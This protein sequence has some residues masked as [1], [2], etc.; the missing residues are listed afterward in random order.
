MPILNV[1]QS[2][3]EATGDERVIP[4]LTKYFKWQLAVPEQDFVLGDWAPL[5]TGDNLE[6]V[7]WLYN[8]TGEKFLLDLAAKLHR[9]S[10]NWGA[11]IPT[12]HG[13]NFTQGFR[14]PA[15]FW[16]QAKDE[17]LLKSTYRNYD[18]IMKRYGQMPGGM[19]IADENFRPGFHDPRGGAE[20]C[21]MV[22]LLH[23]FEMLTKITGDPRWSDRCEDVAF[24]SLPAAFTPDLKGLHYVTCPNQVSLDPKDKTPAIQNGGTMFSYSPYAVYRC[25]QHN[26]SHGWPYYAEEMWLATSDNGLCVSLY[27]PSEVKAK[28]GDGGAE[29]TVTESTKYPFGE[30]VTFKVSTKQKV[31]FP[32]YLRVPQWC[33]GKVV[34]DSGPG[35]ASKTVGDGYVAVTREWED[36]DVV[37]LSLPMEVK[38]RR[39]EA[40]GNSASIDRGPITYSLEIGEKWERYGG[41]EKWPEWQVTPTTAWNYGLVLDEKDLEDS[42]DVAEKKWDKGPTNPLGRY[43]VELVAKAKKIPNW[44]ADAKGAVGPLQQSPAKSGE[45]E[46]TVVLVPMGA[47]RL[48]IAAFP[49]IGD[50]KDA[51]EWQKP[52]RPPTASHVF[53]GDSVEALNDGVEP[54]NSGDT[55]LPRFTWWDHKGS[56]EWVQYDFD[57]PRKLSKSSVY[58]FDDRATGGG[59]RVPASWTL[60]YRGPAGTWQPVM[61]TAPYQAAADRFNAV[62]FEPV[63]TTGLRLQAQLQNNYSGGILEWRV[64]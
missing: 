28:V 61:P 39:W 56:A 29:V 21:S 22:E 1:M 27:G 5:R 38:V 10:A 55:S 26:V 35:P 48:R 14:E 18:E 50:G 47:A 58:W 20:A 19:F 44:T 12:T 60:L 37:T 42:F 25:C 31:E 41:N 57:A 24:N 4:F 15:E 62:E 23:S 11:G 30:E 16:M 64:E 3:H 7:Y 13:V 6:S 54:K 52:P 59:C 49:V 9:R 36:G 53:S 45:P 34:V 63:E 46:E 51:R 40:N 8:R 33:K 43:D 32:L 17:A 2:W